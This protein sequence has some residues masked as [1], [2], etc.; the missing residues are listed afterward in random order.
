MKK[1]FPSEVLVWLKLLLAED[2]SPEDLTRDAKTKSPKLFGE[3]LQNEQ[4]VQLYEKLAFIVRRERQRSADP[5]EEFNVAKPQWDIQKGQMARKSLSCS[6][7]VG[8]ADIS[9]KVNN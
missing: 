5:A 2:L 9:M 8:C 6:V 4:D 1:T 3:V 7:S